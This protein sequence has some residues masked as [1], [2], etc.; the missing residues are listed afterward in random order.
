MLHQNLRTLEQA[1]GTLHKGEAAYR[2]DV[3]KFV[4][5]RLALQEPL[6]NQMKALEKGFSLWISG[7]GESI[8]MHIGNRPSKVK[9]MMEDVEDSS[10]RLLRVVAELRMMLYTEAEKDAAMKA[11]WKTVETLHLS[12]SRT[13]KKQAVAN[14]MKALDDFE[15]VVKVVTDFTREFSFGLLHFVPRHKGEPDGADEGNS[16]N[17][18]GDADGDVDGDVKNPYIANIIEAKRVSHLFQR[19]ASMAGLHLNGERNPIIE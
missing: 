4:S 9:K 13:K 19:V 14:V 1:L 7:H 18:D 2:S 3:N 16:E 12:D 5:K 15:S 6:V 17:A 10:F 11:L 8:G